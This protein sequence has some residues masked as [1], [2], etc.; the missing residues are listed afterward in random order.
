MKKLLAVILCLLLI[1]A[2][3][4]GCRETI[5]DISDDNPDDP[6]EAAETKT[7]KVGLICIGDENDQG[8][9]YNFIRGKDAATEALAAKGI[10][11]EWLVKWNIGE[12]ATCEDANIELAEAGCELIINNSYGFEDYMLKVAPNYP[13]VHFIA[14]TGQESWCDDLYNTHNAFADIYEGRYL[15]GI[16]A[17][18]KLN[19]LIEEGEIAEDEAIIGYVGAFPHTEVVS[20]MT[21]YFLG[22]RS[23][24]PSATMKVLFTDTWS[25][26]T[27]E[28]NAAAVLI[29]TG[30]VVLSQHADNSTPASVAEEKGAYFTSYNNDMIDVAPDAVLVG[31][32][33]D[34]G[35]YFTAI[36][37]DAVNGTEIP[38]DWSLGIANEAVVLTPL[39]EAI[40]APGTAE[41]L[42]EVEAGIKDGTIK[43]FDVSN[44]TVDGKP[45]T[46]A[47]ALD[48]DGDGIPDAEEAIIDGEFKESFYQSAPYFN[49]RIDGIEW[50]NG[51]D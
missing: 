46:Q 15:A 49:I 37:E 13:E 35:V 3:F 18:M 38:Q 27:V 44:F 33:I 32:R 39:N 36:I 41:K 11:V 5:A 12:D 50:L 9:T 31:T 1:T 2:M 14:C 43:V 40:A 7:V 22:A 29:D 23:V 51:A 48:T 30:C 24:C 16:V 4:A 6:T 47:F 34:W 17:G 21:A 45:L 28:A 25:D 20:G 42:A 26:A 19:Q 10:E 8:Y